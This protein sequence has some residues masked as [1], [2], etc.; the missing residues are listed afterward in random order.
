MQKRWK[1]ADTL[2]TPKNWWIGDSGINMLKGEPDDPDNPIILGDDII[3][4]FLHRIPQAREDLETMLPS[5]TPGEQD[6]IQTLLE[7]NPFASQPWIGEVQ[8]TDAFQNRLNTAGVY[9]S[10]PGGGTGRG[11]LPR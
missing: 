9:T 6:R 8:R 5:L 4:D 2:T 11:R 1:E 10:G 3:L 7:D